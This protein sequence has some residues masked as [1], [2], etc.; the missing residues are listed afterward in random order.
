MG[1]AQD[2]SRKKRPGVH[3][4]STTAGTACPSGRTTSAQCS[5]CGSRSAAN[6]PGEASGP[7]PPWWTT[8]CLTGET[9]SCSLIRLTTRACVS[10]ATTGKQPGKWPKNE[11]KIEADSGK[12]AERLGARARV[13]CA[14]AHPR[15]ACGFPNPLPGPKLF[16]AR[17][18]KTAGIPPY[19]IFSPRGRKAGK[20][21]RTCQGPDKN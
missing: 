9:G 21:L 19:E 1:T 6:A 16:G 20:E 2:T 15:K 7:G 14:Y 12:T 18:C 13:R 10:A 8:W 17:V 4:R 3:R 5:S 11:R